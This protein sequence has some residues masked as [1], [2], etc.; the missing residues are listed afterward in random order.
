[1]A[2]INGVPQQ[3]STMVDR[4]NFLRTGTVTQVDPFAVTLEFTVATTDGDETTVIRA[5]Y[6]RQSAPEVGD[7][8]AV[9]RQGAS[10]FVQGT[11]SAT[12]GNSVQN[13]SFEELTTDV[14]PAGW[15]LYAVSGNPSMTSTELD[16]AVEGD[17]VLEVT[18]AAGAS[19]SAF[20]YSLPISVE[21]GQVWELSAYFNGWYPSE[22]ADTAD[23]ELRGLWFADADDLYPTTA[24][25]DSTA[26]TRA[27]ITED[28]I[29]SVIR[30]TVTV[31]AAAAFMRVG[32]RSAMLAYTG[33][34]W[35]FVTAR[36]LS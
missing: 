33:T 8:V 4:F 29:M 12:G 6:V 16:L 36:R 22:N 31:P 13:P 2:G 15:T 28:D 23:V 21:T 3:L 10:W 35:D 25:A 34:R 27:N 1:M 14:L 19:A 24:A 18:P 11:S 26:A 7:L 30:G 32:L 5:A 9:Q 20:V 17:R